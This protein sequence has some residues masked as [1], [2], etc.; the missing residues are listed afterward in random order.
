MLLC[1]IMIINGRRISI[2]LRK[3]EWEVL[4]DIC[5]REHMKLDELCSEIE[6]ER[7]KVSLTPEM[8]VFALMYFRDIVRKQD[9]KENISPWNYR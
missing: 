2:C 5:R 6:R 8:R 3:E 4:E 1:K 7:K 9:R